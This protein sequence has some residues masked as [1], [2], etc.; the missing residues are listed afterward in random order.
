MANYTLHYNPFSICSTMAR[1]TLAFRKTPTP[2]DPNTFT[3]N[4]VDISKDEQ[5]SEEFLTACNP[6]GQVPAMTSSALQSPLTDSLDITYYL[7]DL[8]PNLAPKEQKE[9]IFRLLK[10]LHQ[11]QYLSLSFTPAQNRAGRITTAIEKLMER[12]DISEKYREA[13]TYKAQ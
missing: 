8:Y 3:E 6:K 9:E 2:P 10:E 12:E 5:L 1:V 4:L 11:I 13:L 7:C